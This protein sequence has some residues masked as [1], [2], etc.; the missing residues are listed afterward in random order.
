MKLLIWH[1]AIP[2]FL[3]HALKVSIKAPWK[4]QCN[5]IFHEASLYI[6]K[7]H[8]NHYFDFISK[9]SPLNLSIQNEIDSIMT[10]VE[11]LNIAEKDSLKKAL[12]LR[13]ESINMAQ[14]MKFTKHITTDP[15]IYINDLLIENN[16]KLEEE[17]EKTHNVNYNDYHNTVPF[18][19]L[20]WKH[21]DRPLV[22]LY[23]SPSNLKILHSKLFELGKQGKIS[24][25]LILLISTSSNLSLDQRDCKRKD[26]EINVYGYGVSIEPKGNAFHPSTL[27][28]E[29]NFKGLEGL[30]FPLSP[31]HSQQKSKKETSKDKQTSEKSSD[32]SEEELKHLGLQASNLIIN[33]K[34]PFDAWKNLVSNLPLFYRSL[35]DHYKSNEPNPSLSKSVQNIKRMFGDSGEFITINGFRVITPNINYIGLWEFFSNYLGI[36][37]K[38]FSS[39]SHSSTFN[40]DKDG[41]KTDS[42]SKVNPKW[43]G[44]VRDLLPSFLYEKD[45]IYN[46]KSTSIVYLNN[47]EDDPRLARWTMSLDVFMRPSQSFYP[48][49]RNAITSI[50]IIDPF[51]SDSKGVTNEL[52]QYFTNLI[53]VRIGI[54]LVDFKRSEKGGEHR[55]SL[56]E[57]FYLLSEAKDKEKEKG[58]ISVS[59]LLEYLKVIIQNPEITF[60]MAIDKVAEAIPS[61]TLTASK[62]TSSF[63]GLEKY[64]EAHKMIDRLSIQSN[65]IIVNG[66]LTECN[67]NINSK[68]NKKIENENS[69]EFS[70]SQS[71]LELY[72]TCVNDIRQLYGQKLL[73]NDDKDILAIILDKKGALETRIPSFYPKQKIMIEDSQHYHNSQFNYYNSNDS[74]PITIHLLIDH[75]K[76]YDLLLTVHES[77][78]KGHRLVV[79]FYQSQLDQLWKELSNEKIN[80]ETFKLKLKE[81]L[82]KEKLNAAPDDQETFNPNI[83]RLFKLP[84][85]SNSTLNEKK[86]KDKSAYIIIN[87]QIY[88]PISSFKE[89]KPKDL[90][91]KYN[92]IASKIGNSIKDIQPVSQDYQRLTLAI[93]DI[94]ELVKG[95]FSTTLFASIIPP[96]PGLDQSM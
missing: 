31:S 19:H 69:D 1:W 61:F 75:E 11:F 10:I 6:S 72:W 36:I 92:L 16:D 80:W 3:V 57:G 26:S 37:S 93:Y 43:Y 84:R 60:S 50:M 87:G 77:L 82:K 49:S 32:L 42:P 17:I 39:S 81:E 90:Q 95:P 88:G 8:S 56:L 46:S 23:S 35:A 83:Q 33:S 78:S 65:T 76:H 45:P 59:T 86:I 14:V 9:F 52:D 28:I 64:I 54:V 34:S 66:H 22:R 58:K 27:S 89:I 96:I 74:D 91:F 71:L 20:F 55:Q 29:H 25:S 18:E 47:L 5:S 4:D 30:P 24:Y 62:L 13:L 38:H 85:I 40:L 44:K 73:T 2:I 67:N 70:C 63:D 15:T 41:K 94:V 7:Y 12:E 53:P 68:N 21:K 79:H 51:H 48:V